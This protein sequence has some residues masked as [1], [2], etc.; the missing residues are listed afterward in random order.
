MQ[1][2]YEQDSHLKTL[3]ETAIIRD[4]M[5]LNPVKIHQ[6]SDLVKAQELFQ[7]H[8]ASHLVVVN[9]TNQLVGLISPKYLYKTHSPRK[10]LGEAQYTDPNYIIDGDSFYLKDSL[11]KYILKSI[12]WDDPITLGPDDT[13]ARAILSMHRRKVSCIPIIN[14]DKQIL[15]MITNQEIINFITRPL[16]E[17]KS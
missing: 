1:K 8:K 7:T 13:V 11:D 15:G 4:V 5:N 14:P 17:K 9:D 12:M 10:I 6:D 2:I 16:L 3:L